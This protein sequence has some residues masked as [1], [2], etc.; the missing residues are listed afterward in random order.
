ML[1]R[2]WHWRSNAPD[3]V[4]ALMSEEVILGA[5]RVQRARPESSLEA[6]CTC[7]GHW[8]EDRDSEGRLRAH[9]GAAVER[10]GSHRGWTSGLT[11]VRMQ[12][13]RG[14]AGAQHAGGAAQGQGAAGRR[15]RQA[16]VCERGRNHRGDRPR[17]GALLPGLP[18]QQPQGARARHSSVPN[19]LLCTG[20]WKGHK[21]AEQVPV[22]ATMM[23]TMA[24]RAAYSL[25]HG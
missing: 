11:E 24:H 5:F 16:G 22:Y 4:P 15:G 17:A 25:L 1:R 13:R 14:R 19:L 3:R 8:G 20:P 10:R 18:G 2:G 7:R 6:R 21:C 23:A 12:E 9:V